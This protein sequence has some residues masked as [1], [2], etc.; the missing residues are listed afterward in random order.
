MSILASLA[1]SLID[2][3]V[4]PD[5]VMRRVICHLVHQTMGGFH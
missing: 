1:L 2:R 3:G 4:I 5:F